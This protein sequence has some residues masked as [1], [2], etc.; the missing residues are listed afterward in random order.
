MCTV[1]LSVLALHIY[2]VWRCE[3]F[4]IT[5]II[6]KVCESLKALQ[7]SLN[8]QVVPA[9]IAPVQP[10]PGIHIKLSRNQLVSS[11]QESLGCWQKTTTVLRERERDMQATEILLKVQY[12]VTVVN[13]DSFQTYHN[14]VTPSKHWK[15]RH[16]PFPVCLFVYLWCVLRIGT[17]YLKVF[18]KDENGLRTSEHVFSLATHKYLWGAFPWLGH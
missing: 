12:A 15:H 1:T 18:L 2:T 14:D 11:C 6:R 17:L 7:R 8:G 10:R 13:N 9:D 4:V 5:V 16:V 3:C